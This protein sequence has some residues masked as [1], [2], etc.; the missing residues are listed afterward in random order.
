MNKHFGTLTIAA[1]SL[2]LCLSGSIAYAGSPGQSTTGT[3]PDCST[4]ASGKSKKD[5]DKI[6]ADRMSTK[7]KPSVNTAGAATSSSTSAASTS[8]TNSA[9]ASN[10]T[11]KPAAAPTAETKGDVATDKKTN[12]KD[13]DKVS[14]DRMSTRGLKPPAKDAKPA[15]KLEADT[16]K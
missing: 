2:V 16:P 12:A 13:S 1:G 15:P 14:A 9:A 8:S 6:S 7:A 4:D 10:S 11:A 3:K 5:C